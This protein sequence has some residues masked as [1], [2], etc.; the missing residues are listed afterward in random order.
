[1]SECSESTRLVE[2][3]LDD[4]PIAVEM[5][6]DKRG[7]MKVLPRSSYVPDKVCALCG[8]KLVGKT[9]IDHDH[10]TGLIRGELHGTCNVH[11][12]HWEKSGNWMFNKRSAVTLNKVMG[13][14]MQAEFREVRYMYESQ[15]SIA[16]RCWRVAQNAT[17][18]DDARCNALM[19]GLPWLWVWTLACQNKDVI[20]WVA[21]P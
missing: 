15:A 8:R 6:G 1:M 20:P 18:K 5:Y 14:L 13:Y 11:L 7:S 2:T 3:Y 21:S 17:S 10:A 16:R 9:H 19:R 12:G 4:N